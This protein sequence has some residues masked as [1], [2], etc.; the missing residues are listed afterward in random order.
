VT[1]LLNLL[2]NNF[3]F[4]G[5]KDAFFFST[6]FPTRAV[7]LKLNEVIPLCID[8][9]YSLYYIHISVNTTV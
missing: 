8:S 7:N 2:A 4:C 9:I 1:S 5:Q 6:V 3:G